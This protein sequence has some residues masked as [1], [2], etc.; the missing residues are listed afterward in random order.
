MRRNCR[1]KKTAEIAD[2]I[3]QD[4]K[5]K[6]NNTKL[7]YDYVSDFTV[8][9]E[10]IEYIK[11]DPMDGK[12]IGE[13]PVFDIDPMTG[14]Q[15]QVGTEPVYE[16]KWKPERLYA[17]NVRRAPA[18]QRIGESPYLIIDRCVDPDD[19]MAAF[20]DV[21]DKIKGII[22][23]SNR[24][25]FM[26]FDTSTSTYRQVEDQ[27][28]YH[29]MVIR[30]CKAYPMGKSISWID[31]L[32]LGS[33]DLPFGVWPIAIG[34]FDTMQ[35]TPRGVSLIRTIKHYQID[36]N[37]Q[38]S[39]RAET[40]VAYG[41]DKVIVKGVG[42][43]N[44]DTRLDGMRQF[45]TT[46]QDV[47]VVPGRDGSQYTSSYKDDLS[48]MYDVSN[49]R[50]DSEPT[51]T[52]GKTDPWFMLYQNMRSKKN[53]VVHAEEFQRFLTE[54]CAIY[55]EL[56]KGYYF[57]EM[58]VPIV[59]KNEYLNIDEFKNSNPMSTE[60]R[61]EPV[62]EDIDEL[63]GKLLSIQHLIQYVGP[64][65]TPEQIGMLMREMPYLNKSEIMTRFSGKYDMAKNML[66]ALDSGKQPPV[67]KGEDFSYMLDALTYRMSQP[68][69]DLLSEDIKAL[70]QQ[71]EQQYQQQIAQQQAEQKM[72]EAGSI[73]ASGPLVGVDY[74][75]PDPQRK[76]GTTRAK[77]PMD[78]VNW[79]M[80]KLETQGISQAQL[81]QL[82]QQDQSAIGMMTAQL[83][84]GNNPQ[85]MP[86]DF[87]GQNANL[88]QMFG[89]T[90]SGNINN[91]P[92]A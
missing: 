58:M 85:S 47:T 46:G 17:F 59:G 9:S 30:P 23:S 76:N 24:T 11:Y 88:D 13:S 55:L 32:M 67:R 34:Q 54:R 29:E 56:A 4:I 62:G 77:L 78:A 74:Y 61:V 5:A 20:P 15:I 89:G 43:L 42:R 27:V 63:M 90:P 8:I 92:Q 2:S 70:Y 41:Q 25:N 49:V 75:V 53:Y 38:A 68:D 73:P 28:I 35:T 26:V 79:L 10:C 52:N 37:R 86:A 65:M 48:E 16:G 1:I 36:L 33:V 51:Q 91:R 60:I 31:G 81:N 87:S 18:C 19:L 12:I 50:E 3:W 40:Q 7:V 69:Y 82:S 84:Q 57:P 45:S 39:S 83:T 44:E 66:L 64:Q 6:I 21:A 14:Q 22:N 80:Q 71:R 72:A